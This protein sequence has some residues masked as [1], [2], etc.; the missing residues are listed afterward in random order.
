MAWQGKVRQGVR[1]GMIIP[2]ITVHGMAWHGMAWHGMAWQGNGKATARQRQ[3]NG[4]ATARQG[5]ARQ[6]KA[7][8]KRDSIE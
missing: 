4:K 5:K 7:R 3:G 2:E 8:K 6:G 1:H